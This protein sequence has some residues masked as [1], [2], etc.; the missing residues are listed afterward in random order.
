MRMRKILLALGTLIT[1]AVPLAIQSPA[2]A[3]EARGTG[4]TFPIGSL[5]CH[6]S[7]HMYTLTGA[8]V[9]TSTVVCNGRL[10]TMVSEASVARSSGGVN[11][12]SRF[13]STWESGCSATT[14]ISNPSGTPQI[15][16]NANC[17][18]DA[19]GNCPA[20]WGVTVTFRA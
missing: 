11:G 3:A 10:A 12:S 17:T 13:C 20:G 2:H 7:V 1:V 14:S 5:R 8:V 9:V 4:P 15:A 19:W 18:M 16:G 6:N